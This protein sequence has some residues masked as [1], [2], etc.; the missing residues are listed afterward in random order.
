MLKL[1]C[2]VLAVL[3][4]VT[5]TS[6][7]TRSTYHKRQGDERAALQQLK[8]GYQ[9]AVRKTFNAQCNEDNVIIRKEWGDMSAAER[10]DYIRATRCLNSAPPKTPPSFAP[11][12]RN[13]RDDFTVAHI[14]DYQRVHFSPWTL[15]FHTWYIWLYEQALRNE[16]GYKGGLPYMAYE[17]YGYQSLEQTPMFDGSD[18]SLGT[19]GSPQPDGCSCTRG[20]FADFQCHLGPVRGGQACKQNP[21]ADGLGYNPRCLERGFNYDHLGNLTV[22]NV[23]DSITAY[24][25]A[26]NFCLRLEEWPGGL[27]P[28]PHELIGGAQNDIPGS[29]CDPWFFTHHAGLD[30][31]WRLWQSLDYD[32]RTDALPP[33][34]QYNRERAHRGW[35]PADTVTTDSWINMSPVLDG[36]RVGDAMSATGGPLCFIY[37]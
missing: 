24:D 14:S 19:N 28:T 5:A 13:R 8:Q 23:Y 15:S 21:Q 31:I 4:A 22:E 30:F 18:T 9:E 2:A 33:P 6:E 25:D 7:H 37:E 17:R 34:E 32:G 11:G 12:A 36:I 3:P 1:I 35:Q 10:E 20:P 26:A 16:C 29:P 27:H